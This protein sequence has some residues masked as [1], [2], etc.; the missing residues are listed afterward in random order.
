MFSMIA[1]AIFKRIWKACAPD[2]L[3]APLLLVY[4]LT[5]ICLSQESEIIVK[6]TVCR[7]GG[8]GAKPSCV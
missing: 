8:D 3:S 5:H 7:E 4:L 2:G 6:Q 1:P